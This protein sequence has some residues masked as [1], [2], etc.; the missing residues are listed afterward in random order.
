MYLK[1]SF[2]SCETRVYK[3]ET[4]ITKKCVKTKSCKTKCN[5]SDDSC[6]KCC[7]GSLCNKDDGRLCANNNINITDIPLF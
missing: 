6:V 1:T 5:P 2:Q 4:K 7:T 3:K